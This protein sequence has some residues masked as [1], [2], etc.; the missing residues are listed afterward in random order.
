MHV[1]SISVYEAEGYPADS[2]K[3]CPPEV[4]P[5]G[6]GPA[7]KAN[8]TSRLQLCRFGTTCPEMDPSTGRLIKLG[9]DP[10]AFSGTNRIIAGVFLSLGVLLCVGLAV[11]FREA[12]GGK[13]AS[14]FA[15]QQNETLTKVSLGFSMLTFLLT[16]IACGVNTWS[17]LNDDYMGLWKI[18]SSA[19]DCVDAIDHTEGGGTQWMPLEGWGSGNDAI[20]ATRFFMMTATLLTIVGVAIAGLI[21]AAK[22]D[23]G[24][25]NVS[26]YTSLAAFV[27]SLVAVVAWAAFHND[28]LSPAGGQMA[29]EV[30]LGGGFDTAI[31]GCLFSLATAMIDYGVFSKFQTGAKL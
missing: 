26:F 13:I 7:G 22:L 12:I 5:C 9:F 20:Y 11:K 19:G 24:R 10:D 17:T 21:L 4:L 28:V 1:L 15:G 2:I 30:S 14:V 6:V 23:A 8:S 29:M 18:C 3:E 27:C 25:A 31:A 16:T